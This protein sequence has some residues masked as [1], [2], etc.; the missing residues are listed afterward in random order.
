MKRPV[1]GSLDS[2]FISQCLGAHVQRA[3]TLVR[4]HTHSYSDSLLATRAQL[5]CKVLQFDWCSSCGLLQMLTA[6]LISG[7]FASEKPD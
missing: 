3:R 6:Q 7:G 4:A 1:D 2:Q 5:N